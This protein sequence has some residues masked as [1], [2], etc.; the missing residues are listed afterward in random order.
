MQQANLEWI[1]HR[2][3]DYIKFGKPM[4]DISQTAKLFA[5]Y[6]LDCLRTESEID[7]HVG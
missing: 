7:E 5:A 6:C 1:E 2:W 4:L 3:R